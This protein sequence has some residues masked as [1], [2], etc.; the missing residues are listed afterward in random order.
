MQRNN[1]I[2]CKSTMKK[3][4][5]VAARTL[6]ENLLM[7][8]F[9]DFLNSTLSNEERDALVKRNLKRNLKKYNDMDDALFW[10]K[11]R[12]SKDLVYFFSEVENV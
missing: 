1:D 10:Q 4:M 2:L 3:N 7:C 11:T 5:S 9:N 12:L 6:C 8:F